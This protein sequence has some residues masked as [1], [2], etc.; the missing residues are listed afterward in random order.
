MAAAEAFALAQAQAQA[1]P[2]T[3]YGSNAMTYLQYVKWREKRRRSDEE[4]LFLLLEKV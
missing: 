1:T 4:A 2:P 3:V